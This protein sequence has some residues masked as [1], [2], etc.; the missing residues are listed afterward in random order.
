MN[1][2]PVSAKQLLHSLYKI[3]PKLHMASNFLLYWSSHAMYTFTFLL[4]LF[5]IS[6]ATTLLPIDSLLFWYCS[7]C[8]PESRRFSCLSYWVDYITGMSQCA[9]LHFHLLISF[10]WARDI[11]QWWKNSNH[12]QMLRVELSAWQ[13]HTRKWILRS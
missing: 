13:T 6:F 7:P 3:H 1:W 11:A 9:R 12:I 5:L 2:F 8:W 4:T 10:T